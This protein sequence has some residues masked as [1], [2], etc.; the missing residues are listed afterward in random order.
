MLKQ[1]P[2]IGRLL[3]MALFTL[4]CFGL[5]LFL[6]TAF[7][8]STPLRAGGYRVTIP[9]KESGQ[10]SQQA[11]VRISGVPVGKVKSI[12]ADAATG[13]SRVVV[14]I[15]PAYAPIP[16]D[17]RVMLRQKTL[18]GETYVELTPGNPAS[19]ELQDGG[20][21]ARGAIAPTVELDEVLRAFD[22]PTRRA[23]QTWQEQ[24]ALANVGRGRDLSDAIGQLP[25]L[26]EQAT[27]LLTVLREQEGGL[28]A[29]VRDTG[30]VFDAISTNGTQLADLIS[31]ANTVF[32]TTAARD[33]QLAAT[34]EALPTFQRESRITLDRL[35]RF[36]DTTDPLVRQLQPVAQQS[37]PTLQALERLAPQLSGVMTGLGPAQDA[38]VKGLPAV[39]SL[40]AELTPFIGKLSPT[41]AQVNPLAQFVGAYPD[42][43]TSFFGNTVAST[44]AESDVGGKAVK[45]LRVT[46]PLSPEGLASYSQ[47]LVSNRS[48]AYAQPNLN[49]LLAGANMPVYESRGC[50]AGL[51]VALDPST[52]SLIGQ[53]LTD[54]IV[55]YVFA[56]AP[57]NVP[58][59]GCSQQGMFTTGIGTSR[60]PR[61][62]PG[63]TPSPLGLP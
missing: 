4:S 38:S 54:R 24:L 61:V 39:N 42:E 9:F 14:E 57:L 10:L 32:A 5:L 6:W 62:G 8:G 29:L 41:L 46:N 55:K 51:N 43:L 2:S 48:N 19:G 17:S 30:V 53:Q 45:Y 33:R 22:A 59:P 52:P 58:A 44:N 49:K 20:T 3:A 26:E 28:S 23:F 56:G 40:L 21:L 27:A 47:R 15:D 36:A 12:K 31:N 35:V 60:F 63:A 1:G 7:G 34:F 37:G 13:D 50:T 18:L 16:R 25:A 11:D